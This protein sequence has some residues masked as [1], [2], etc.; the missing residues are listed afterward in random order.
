MASLSIARWLRY[1]ISLCVAVLAVT[2]VCGCLSAAAH[3][4]KYHDQP[5]LYSVLNTQVKAGDSMASAGTVQ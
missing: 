3:Y 5:S 1:S 4:Q 2:L